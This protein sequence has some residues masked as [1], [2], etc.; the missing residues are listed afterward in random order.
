MKKGGRSIFPPH[1]MHEGNTVAQGQNFSTCADSLRF[2]IQTI[3]NFLLPQRGEWILAVGR[4]S[5]P[6][7]GIKRPT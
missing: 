5:G 6:A 3:Y 4:P 7:H 1:A 2:D